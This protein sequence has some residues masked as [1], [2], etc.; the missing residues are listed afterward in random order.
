MRIEKTDTAIDLGCGEGSITIPLAK[1]VSKVTA[2]DSSGKMLEILEDKCKEESIDNMNI[3]HKDLEEITVDDVGKQDIVL[4]S[5]S[6]NGIFPIKK[7]IANLNEIANKYVYITLFGP[8]N[9]K[10]EHDF[11]DSINKKYSEFASY[12]Y[13]FNIL[14]D[15]GIYPNIENLEIKKNRKY[16]SIEDVMEN[17]KWNLN[18]YSE[19]EKEQLKDYLKN[20]LKKNQYGKLYNKNDKADWIL[21]WWRK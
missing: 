8:N 14:I 5:R 16:D 20:N 10:F 4:A 9:W 2:V 6:I 21:I 1:K 18:Q 15:M 7:T 12:S 13:F 11:Y 3:I 19:E 17:G